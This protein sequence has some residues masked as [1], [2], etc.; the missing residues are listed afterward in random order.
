MG[1][2][3]A[4]QAPHT[5]RLALACEVAGIDLRTLQRWK[6]D[7]TRLTQGDRRPQ[8]ARATPAHALTPQE[9]DA[10][11]QVANEPRFAELPPRAHRADAGR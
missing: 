8:A 10:I 2:L 5:A 11:L 9:R 1:A 4:W 3:P 6:A 7:E